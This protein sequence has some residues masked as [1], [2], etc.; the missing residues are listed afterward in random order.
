MLLGCGNV[1]ENIPKKYIDTSIDFDGDG[2][3]RKDDCDDMDPNR[4]PGAE[5]RCDGQDN[6][7]DV[8][9]DEEPVDGI[10]IWVDGDGD[11]YGDPARP[12]MACMI[13]AGFADNPAD[14]NDENPTISPRATEQCDD[15]DNNCDG[16]VDDHTAIGAVHWFEDFDGDGYGSGPPSTK[17]CIG[18]IH[19]VQNNQDC[20]D[21]NIDVHP[22]ADEVCDGIDNDCDG[23]LDEP[24]AIGSTVHYRDADLD[25][26]GD[27]TETVLRCDEN[28]DFVAVADDCDDAEP[29]SYPGA[30]EGCDGVD[31]TCDGFIDERCGTVHSPSDAHWF[32]SGSPSSISVGDLNDDGKIDMV[33]AFADAGTLSLTAGPLAPAEHSP[34]WTAS[35]YDE[36]ASAVMAFHA[37]N[38][39]N[40]DGNADLLTAYPYM[41]GS[42]SLSEI[43][44]HFGPMDAPPALDRPDARLRSQF[45]DATVLH[46]RSVWFSDITGDDQKDILMYTTPDNALL[47][48]SNPEGEMTTEADAI[49]LATISIDPSS[50]ISTSDFSGDGHPDLIIGYPNDRQVKLFEGP[51]TDAVS[52]YT[53][54]HILSQPSPQFGTSVC[55]AELLEDGHLTLAISTRGE[56]GGPSRIQLFSG[57]DEYRSSVAHVIG[58]DGH[59]IGTKLL[60]EDVDGD[61]KA[62]LLSSHRS[63]IEGDGGK[64]GTLTMFHGSLTHLMGGTTEVDSR[65][66]RI[67]KGHE[68]G[69]TEWLGEHVLIG[70]FDDDGVGDLMATGRSG[71][72]VFSG[73]DWTSSSWRPSP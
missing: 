68:D 25:G 53:A 5:E 38:D 61:G 57:S 8:H 1:T 2:V 27:A 60:C 35:S 34:L 26:F 47:L 41:T 67:W 73:S 33:T 39:I 7:C 18:Q 64:A 21:A 66:D 16:R 45:G 70:D 29:T 37:T 17:A 55:G 42:D 71:I 48:W 36:S 20:D 19:E 62:D 23:R 4:F 13:S 69:T 56:D 40:G 54:D 63:L 22:A 51:I 43:R 9:V 58:R 52:L 12:V 44:I 3:S 50:S 49:Q 59:H 72:Y 6:D 28:I 14:C 46:P 65:A 11:G 30:E 24:G 15:V 32:M 31:N 10:T